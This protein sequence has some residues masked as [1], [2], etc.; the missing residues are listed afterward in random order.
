[1]KSIVFVALALVAVAIAAPA[2]EEPEKIISSDFVKKQDGGYDYNFETAKG[3]SRQE[4]GELK[5][6]LD[7]DN[8]PQ[9]VVVV[10]GSY[11]YINNEGQPET[12]N[13]YADETGF[14]AEGASIPKAPVA[15]R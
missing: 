9:N 10:R 14:H 6:V 8:K 1:M 7:E 5:E 11:T 15:R 2:V 4:N 12:I 3:I 13:Y